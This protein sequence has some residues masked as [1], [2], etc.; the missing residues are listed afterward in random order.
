M[1]MLYSMCTHVIILHFTVYTCCMFLSDRKEGEEGRKE[2]GREGG[3]ERGRERRREGKREGEKEGGKE[4]GRVR[5]KRRWS[6]TFM[7]E[8]IMT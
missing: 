1:Y 4:G 7:E 2:R 5:A 3:R 8:G 6:S